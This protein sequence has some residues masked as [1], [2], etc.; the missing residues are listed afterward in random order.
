MRHLLSVAL[1]SQLAACEPVFLD[2]LLAD[3]TVTPERADRVVWIGYPVS[4]PFVLTNQSRVGLD[5]EAPVLFG[6]PALLGASV[7]NAPARVESASTA[8]VDIGV[9]PQPGADGARAE[10][11]L[12]VTPVDDEVA[13]IE[14]VLAVEVRAPP[15]CVAR[16]PCETAAFDAVLGECVR[17]A[18]PDG[19]TCS[20]GSLCTE[21]DRCSSGTCVGR[22]VSCGDLV[23]CTLDSC[24]PERG[25]VFEPIH[26]RCE[27]DNAC[28]ADSCVATSGCVRSVVQDGTPC[29]PFSCAQLQT[30]F[31]GVC[32]AAPT[33]DGFPCE[34]GDLCTAGDSC[35]AQ[36]CVSG[37]TVAPT[38][39]PPSPI[40]R[41]TIHVD[42][43]VRWYQ[44]EHLDSQPTDP[45][46]GFETTLRFGQALD[47]NQGLVGWRPTLAV[48]WKSEPFGEYGA[49]CTPWDMWAVNRNSMD[50][51]FC[52][53]A[54]V[55][56]VLD[57][58]ELARAEGGT[59]IVVGLAYGTVDASFVHSDDD[60]MVDDWVPG[61]AVEVLIAESTYFPR[62]DPGREIHLHRVGVSLSTRSISARSTSY[63]YNGPD[64]QVESNVHA[65]LRVADLGG[66]PSLVGWDLPQWPYLPA[67]A[68]GDGSGADREAPPDAPEGG[69]AMMPWVE[70][71]L[72]HGLISAEAPPDGYGQIGWSPLIYDECME[73]PMAAEELAFR[74]VDV[75]RFEGRA[76]AVA[77]HGLLGGYADGCGEYA[78]PTS[79]SLFPLDYFD[80]ADEVPWVS[81]GDDVLSVSITGRA[82]ELAL[83]R[84]QLCNAVP[85]NCPPFSLT[86]MTPPLGAVD[87]IVT[88]WTVPLGDLSVATV[89]A[90]ALEPRFG[91]VGA[92]ALVRDVLGTTSV[93]LLDGVDT[94]SPLVLAT[95]PFAVAERPARA[96]RSPLSPQSVYAAVTLPPPPTADALVEQASEGAVVRFGCPFPSFPS[97]VTP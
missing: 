43:D 38:A 29:G 13:P 3:L 97:V 75:F 69:A 31:Y 26:A 56:T 2:A 82:E 17:T 16:D 71:T 44:D 79:A 90:L 15:P 19:E 41:P 25:C 58:G 18:H 68:P 32:V 46:A 84:P 22:A 33:P 34:D 7:L 89:D 80:I 24:D 9:A 88:S 42:E 85:S 92:V 40:A 74:D 60:L 35:Q 10:L 23:D 11:T 5:L 67:P 20:D 64:W 66:A 93:T 47:L 76:W 1:C 49:P 61:D 59:S 12:A 53:T 78:E 6:A 39:Q 51:G 95:A 96:L 55:V 27:D 77:R 37:E 48:L 94:G 36:S 63:Y 52:A 81:L 73:L 45:P 87:P 28:T 4:V 8:L 21:D 65:G 91:A 50:R 83:V 62:P 86:V 14:A 57:E 72:D 30:C 54:V 70:T